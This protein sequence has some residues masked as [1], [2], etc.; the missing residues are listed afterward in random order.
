[1]HIAKTG[2]TTFNLSYLPA[3]FNPDEV[4]VLRGFHAFNIEDREWLSNLPEQ[5]KQS[6]KMIA[7][8]NTESLRPYFPE[9]RFLSVIRNPV[10]RAISA[11]LHSRYH[12]DAHE[13]AG[14]EMQERNMTLQQFVQ[15][16]F[17]VRIQMSVHN[18]Q[19]KLL[20]GSESA[21]TEL[22]EPSQVIESLRSLYH[23]VGYTEAL[24][25]F[26]FYLHVTEGFPLVVFN[27]RLVRQERKSF[28]ATDED[29]AEIKRHNEQDQLVCDCVRAE[30]DRKV[31]EI[32]NDTLEKE[33]REYLAA[34][35]SYRQ[36]TNNDPNQPPMRWPYESA[37]PRP[38]VSP[39]QDSPPVVFSPASAYWRQRS[40]LAGARDRIPAL[41][42]AINAPSD[43][44]LYQY[45]QFIASAI[46]YQPDLVLDSGTSG[47]S[48]SAFLE[49]SHLS[50]RPFPVVALFRPGNWA[51]TIV[52][53]LRR[54]VPNS[55]LEALKF[56]SGDLK[57]VNFAELA[58]DAKRVLFFWD[59][60][61]FDF[62]ERVLGKL[63]PVLAGREHLVLM[64]DLSDARY[65][66]PQGSLYG[67]QRLWKGP[68]QDG[69]RLRLGI[70]DSAQ[71]EAIAA[72]DFTS[73]NQVTLA[74]ADHSYHTE[75]TD[76][77][78]LELQ[79]AMG[80]E[81]FS[82]Q[83]HWF[84]FSLNEHPGPYTFPRYAVR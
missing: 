79:G 21:V 65:C 60:H 78:K 39:R 33:Y 27:N 81:L 8:H 17:G 23:L 59:A 53:N 69:S 76:E 68:A 73:R 19:V 80:P 84:F 42:R 10:D 4:F 30:F 12:G 32:W 56:A 82:L 40:I 43:L 61:G 34:L 35:E 6:F 41:S 67:E 31:A 64:H 55:W 20:F 54:F 9:A 18:A 58:G 77:Q 37:R 28:Q 47:N 25:L 22:R 46:D 1:M 36:L 11:Y 14:K 38:S 45:A 70:I 83:A 7:G 50:A 3:A 29:I 72:L 16:D 57:S 5:Q 74:S 52:P 49:A 71:P 13:P 66:S 63:L 62:A 44:S 48:A 75:L 51:S 26:L 2:G 24:E 15:E